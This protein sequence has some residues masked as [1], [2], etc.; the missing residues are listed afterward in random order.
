MEDAMNNSGLTVNWHFTQRCNMQCTYCFVSKCQE[1]QKKA[2]DIILEK[3]KDQFTRVNFVG[4]EP[5]TSPHLLALMKDAR[6]YGLKTTIVTNGYRMAKDPEFAEKILRSVDMVGI[7]IDS[8]NPD[9]NLRIGRCQ[10]GEPLSADEYISLCKKVKDCGIPLKINTVVSRDNLDEDFTAFYKA[11]QPDRIKL[12]Q[13]LAPNLPTKRDYTESLISKSEYDAFVARH[14]RKG[15]KVV[16]EDNEHMLG[17][18][19]ML[20]SGGCFEDNVH[21]RRSRSLIDPYVTV[22]SALAEVSVDMEKYMY[23][24]SA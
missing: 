2:Y 16:A 17:S 9:T 24:Y 13:V 18:Y 15:F 5:T 8:L 12:F 21:G 7:S 20:N 1:V 23:R 11:V 22:E 10:N 6:G 14:R 4:G 3:L 19:I